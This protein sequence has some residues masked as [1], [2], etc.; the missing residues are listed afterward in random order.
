MKLSRAMVI[1]DSEADQLIAEIA[2][3]MY[4]PNIEIIKAYDGLEALE[5]LK[6]I[7]EQPEIIFLDI[8]MPR[9]N[10]HEFLKVYDKNKNNKS[11]IDLKIRNCLLRHQT[12]VAVQFLFFDR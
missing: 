7:D 2:L 5:I 11:I 3:Q 4:D 8:N 12:M 6:D 1:D 9:M 10:G